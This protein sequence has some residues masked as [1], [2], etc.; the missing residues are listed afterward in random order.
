[1]IQ[2]F[3]YWCNERAYLR[4]ETVLLRKIINRKNADIVAAPNLI[5]NE[6]MKHEAEL[7]AIEL[8]NNLHSSD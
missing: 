8:K 6:R 5:Q 3:L 2:R 4:N 1:M 7:M